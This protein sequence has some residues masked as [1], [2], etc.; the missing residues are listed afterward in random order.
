MVTPLPWSAI[1]STTPDEWT[2]KS[3]ADR[4][5]VGFD[6]ARPLPHADIIDAATDAGID[7]DIPFDR[8]GR[9]RR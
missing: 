9:T 1:D 5:D 4:P 8:F 7:L 3:F 2:I 6:E